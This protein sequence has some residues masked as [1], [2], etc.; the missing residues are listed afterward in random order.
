LAKTYVFDLDGTICEERATFEKFLA[1]PIK[2]MIDLVNQLY[3]RGC[4]III[5]TARSWGEF[6][7]TEKWLKENN[8][9]YDILMC[10]K[11]IYDV[12][13]DDRCCNPED[14]KKDFNDF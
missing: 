14:F 7:I 1:A 3:S 5:Y 6:A 12:W 10:G 13:V 2:E 8:V 11:P 9:K 4:R